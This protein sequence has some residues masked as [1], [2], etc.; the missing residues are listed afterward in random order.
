V[1]VSTHTL[2]TSPRLAAL[3]RGAVNIFGLAHRGHELASEANEPAGH[4]APEFSGITSQARLGRFDANAFEYQRRLAKLHRSGILSETEHQ[5]L[6]NLAL[7]GSST[8]PAASG[9]H[10][11]LSYEDLSGPDKLGALEL[12]AVLRDSGV[13]PNAEFLAQ[14]AKLI[15]AAL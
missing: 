9:T 12:L 6:K 11:A 8:L 4:A 10:P 13:L 7:V 2:A 5:D 14:K 15:S 1:I 3:C